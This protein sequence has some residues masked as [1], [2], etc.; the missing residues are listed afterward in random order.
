[1]KILYHHRVASKDGQ[2]VHIE[3]IVDALTSLGHEIHMVA[4]RMTELSAFGSSGGV[5]SKLKAHLPK[6]L[7]EIIEYSYS[8]FAFVKV[9]WAIWVFRP[10]VVYER[11]N[12][13]FTG[14]I[15]AAKLCK[16][17]ILLEV[18]SPLYE[19]REEYGGIALKR[20]ARWSEYYAWRNADV[21]L[22]VTHVLAEFIKRAGV[23]DKRISVIPNGVD[24]SRFNPALF[25][26]RLPELKG[27]C[28]IGFVGFCREWHHLDKVMSSLSS[29]KRDDIIFL[30]VGDGPVL[31]DLKELAKELKFEKQF[32]STGLVSRKEMPYWISQIDIA[33]QPAVTPWAS[34]L[35][36][37]EYLAMGKAVL[38]DDSANIKELLIDD[39][40]AVLFE[41]GNL[42]D[43]S[44]KLVELV[45]DSKRVF[46]LS[47]NSAKSISDNSLTWRSNAEK[48]VALHNNVCKE[49]M[50]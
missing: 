2:Y 39:Y 30:L 13:L 35:K 24:T 50:K 14:G 5:V 43:M 15:W 46:E 26:E 19:E 1:M 11:Y 45:V 49:P 38:A 16:I 20:L 25:T 41:S 18:N 3:E 21:V 33:L 36:L 34:P 44:N 47:K 40:N 8:F 9:L 22:P 6:A 28:V 48:I 23:P 29:L 4:P 42:D 12:L 32:I 17:P 7:Y 27:K 31:S 37:L 10:D